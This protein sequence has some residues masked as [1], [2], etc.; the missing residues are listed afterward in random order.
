LNRLAALTLSVLSFMA[1]TGLKDG[2]ER[3]GNGHAGDKNYAGAGRGGSQQSGSG[4][5]AQ[6]GRVSA[7][8][9]GGLELGGAGADTNEAGTGGATLG[10][11]D[12]GG[13]DYGGA[14]YGGAHYG[15]AGGSDDDEDLLLGNCASAVETIGQ[16]Y[17]ICACDDG[18]DARCVPGSKTPGT[19]PEQPLLTYNDAQTLFEQ[20]QPGDTVAFCR[21]GA[22]NPDPN[23]RWVNSNNCTPGEPCTIRD[24]VPSW[25]TDGTAGPPRINATTGLGFHLFIGSGIQL[26]NFELRGSNLGLSVEKGVSDV[27]LCGLTLDGFDRGA[28]LSDGGGTTNR[29]KLLDSVVR[30][31]KHEAVTMSSPCKDCVIAGNV[32]EQNA[33]GTYAPTIGIGSGEPSGYEIRKN[34]FRTHSESKTRL[35]LG[36]S[37]TLDG[38]AA[39]GALIASN[40]IEDVSS[41]DAK[42]LDCGRITF[43]GVDLDRVVGTTVSKNRFN[44][45]G[46]SAVAFFYCDDCVIENN[47]YS[48]TVTVHDGDDNPLK[49]SPI[50]NNGSTDRLV[51]RNNT[52][53]AAAGVKTGEAI[54]V[55]FHQGTPYP[56]LVLTNNLVLFL[57]RAETFTF[58]L[59]PPIRAFEFVDNNLCFFTP[60]VTAGWWTPGN[61]LED[62]SQGAEGHD[63]HSL[64]QDPQ[65]NEA[66]GEDFLRPLSLQSPVVGAGAENRAPPDDIEGKAR[67]ASAPDIGAIEH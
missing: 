27:L 45:I 53:F 21:G 8:E 31:S 28:I 38:S 39:D 5:S 20:L 9:G 67:D 33:I 62:W 23:R 51:I 15:G 46:Q 30:N 22:W 43:N 55:G 29:V 14:H 32:F 50:A 12:Y 44:N 6:A 19:D 41:D 65:L 49:F 4:G 48:R 37:I 2:D 26:M 54:A 60:E 24:Y 59:V 36:P 57:A 34:V 52:I 16:T 13:A 42:G 3:P 40:L 11:A 56:D 35:C 58:M 63:T 18:A 17:Y 61:S 66:L 1:C 64:F 10:G 25:D 7:G 47:V